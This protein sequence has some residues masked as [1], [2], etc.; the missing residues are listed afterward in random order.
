MKLILIRHGNTFEKGETPVQV[1]A[2]TDI[3]LT[4]RGR[5]QAQELAAEFQRR[6]F[7]IETIYSGSLSRQRQTAQI[8]SRIMDDIP[9]VGDQP[10]LEEL[11]YGSW[12]GMTSEEIK[13]MSAES[14]SNWLNNGIWP[15]DIFNESEQRRVS[16]LS[17]FVERLFKVHSGDSCVAI[18]SSNGIIRQFARFAHKNSQTSLWDSL[19]IAGEIDSL[20]MKTGSYSLCE[21]SAATPDNS[22]H[23]IVLDMTQWNIVPADENCR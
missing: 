7:K 19:S 9:V 15:I 16:A 5:Q 22:P 6:K 21:L 23:R 11:D 18:V 4:A 12:E 10:G 20:K 14:Y 2:R 8:I 13:K 1:G 17:A 3:E